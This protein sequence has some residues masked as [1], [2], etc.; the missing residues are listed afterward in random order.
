MLPSAHVHKAARTQQK[1]P[2]LTGAAP[3]NSATGA[4]SWSLPRLLLPRSSEVALLSFSLSI[5]IGVVDAPAPVRAFERVILPS[6]IVSAM[7]GGIAAGEV[8]CG[9]EAA[10]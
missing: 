6:V 9:S 1:S 5:C 8:F 4:P 7:L 10:I 3:N 2:I